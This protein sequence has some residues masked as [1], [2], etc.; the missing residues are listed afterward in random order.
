MSSRRPRAS[1]WHSYSWGLSPGLAFLF[2]MLTYAQHPWDPWGQDVSEKKAVGA[3][4]TCSAGAG[5][6]S[7]RTRALEPM[8]GASHKQNAGLDAGQMWSQR[9]CYSRQRPQ[10]GQKDGA[11]TLPPGAGDVGGRGLTEQERGRAG[12]AKLS[13][14]NG[15]PGILALTPSC[16]GSEV[17]N[18]SS[19]D[20]G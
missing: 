14:G 9:E 16:L 5:G 1:G 10:C 13:Q 7:V 20:L 18:C 19:G 4:Q 12:G 8:A 11:W 17:G 3:A 2:L 6:G 15:V